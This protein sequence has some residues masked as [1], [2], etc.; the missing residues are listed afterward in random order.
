MVGRTR[1]PCARYQPATPAATAKRQCSSSSG[2]PSTPPTQAPPKPRKTSLFSMYTTLLEARPLSTKAVTSGVIAFAGDITCQL[3]AM[4]VAKR[5]E[6]ALTEEADE[7]ETDNDHHLLDGGLSPPSDVASE[8]DWGRTTRFALVGAVVVAP[9][10]HVWY[11]VLLRWLPGN[12][13]TTVVKRV[14]LDQLLFAPAFLAAFLSTV[15]LLDGN[16][17]KIENKLRADYTATV[18]G[19]WGYWIPAQL[20]NFRFVAPVYQ[21]L[22]AN[23]VGFFWNIY[24]SYQSNKKVV[25]DSPSDGAGVSR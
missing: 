15:M 14:A 5:E 16:A 2:P 1:L 21:V 24:L 20:I 3:L 10:L 12:A 19:N 6:Q 7:S 9:A 8:I 22:Y 23:F 17:A 13:P 18:V 4:E 11:G 25:K